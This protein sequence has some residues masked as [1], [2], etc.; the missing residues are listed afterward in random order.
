MIEMIVGEW[1]SL[2]IVSYRKKDII[3]WQSGGKS[4][5]NLRR[6]LVIKMLLGFHK[7]LY[8]RNKKKI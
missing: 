7:I 4:R 6:N 3:I 1:K 2:R 5:L 8:E